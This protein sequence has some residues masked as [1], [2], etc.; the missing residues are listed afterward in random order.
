MAVQGEGCGKRRRSRKRRR[1][2][3][4]MMRPKKGETIRE[5][6]IRQA[7]RETDKEKKTCE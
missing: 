4:E 6:L 3:K 5:E 7:V 1:K 2:R